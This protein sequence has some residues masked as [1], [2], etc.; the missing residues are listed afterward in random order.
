MSDTRA[1]VH[2][3]AQASG[4]GTVE[5]TATVQAPPPDPN[6]VI[7]DYQHWMMVYPE[8]SAVTQPRAQAF[9]DQACILCDNTACSPVPAQKPRSTYLDM[10]TA[11]IAALSGGLN[12]C[13]TVTAGQGMGMIGRISSA[14]EGSVSIS[15]E[16]SVNGDGP[17]AA[18]YNQTQYGA[19]YWIATAQYRTWHYFVGPQP[20]PEGNVGSGRLGAW[21]IL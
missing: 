21:P 17:N 3:T 19:L 7:F 2:A 6:I 5:P 9:F 18:W 16:Y 20:F 1:A 10:L 13:G 12:P 8:F 14:T 11:H 15:S 4:I